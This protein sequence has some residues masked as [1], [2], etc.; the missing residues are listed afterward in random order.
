[1]TVTDL[2]PSTL[3]EDTA[4]ALQREKSL[5]MSRNA[6]RCGQLLVRF[7]S[8]ADDLQITVAFTL[9]A[10]R[11]WQRVEASVP[12]RELRREGGPDRGL[13]A[14]FDQLDDGISAARIARLFAPL[15]VAQRM[16]SNRRD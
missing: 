13:I 4:R 2:R 1:M 3:D 7:G 5:F 8:V 10:S 12:D 15:S 14:A 11:Q 9:D 16:A 6:E